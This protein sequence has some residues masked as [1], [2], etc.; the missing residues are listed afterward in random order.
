E[1][2]ADQPRCLRISSSCGNAL[3]HRT[4]QCLRH[5][6]LAHR[7][8]KF[9]KSVREACGRTKAARCKALLSE[10]SRPGGSGDRF[11]VP[12]STCGCVA[13]HICDRPGTDSTSPL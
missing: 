6:S 3:R 9:P 2:S 7:K 13:R 8:F 5:P 10:H 11:V 4:I 1:Y 12:A